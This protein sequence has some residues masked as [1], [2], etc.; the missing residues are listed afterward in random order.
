MSTEFPWIVCYILITCVAFI[1]AINSK[2]PVRSGLSYFLA[3][4]CLV[5][6]GYQSFRL[7]VQVQNKVSEANELESGNKIE[8]KLDAIES[9]EQ[10]LALQ[11]QE[12]LKNQQLQEA[13][14]QKNQEA[15][16]LYKNK[17]LNFLV[18]AKGLNQKLLAHK[19]VADDDT[20]YDALVQKASFFL[21][22]SQDLKRA[23]EKLI[24][25]KGMELAQDLIVNSVDAMVLATTQ[26]RKF[27][28]A[29]SPDEELAL[30]NVYQQ[31]I[32]QASSL[33]AR[34]EQSVQ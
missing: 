2:G 13:E 26:L 27:Y 17:A 3:V 21:T 8:E 20:E 31:K 32:K 7:G 5:L 34:A 11:K 30:T 16:S 9:L 6:S 22:E 10:N 29:E 18:K 24:P 25:P 19:L 23:T 1:G 15:V 33:I 4:L 12:E 28:T 14:I